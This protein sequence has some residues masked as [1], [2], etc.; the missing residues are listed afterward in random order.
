MGRR[1]SQST[2]SPSRGKTS[3]ATARRGLPPSPQGRDRARLPR[4]YLRRGGAGARLTRYPRRSAGES[5][6][7]SCVSSIKMSSPRRGSAL[8][9]CSSSSPQR[10]GNGFAAR[11]A[12]WHEKARRPDSVIEFEWVAVTPEQIEQ[13]GLPTQPRS[14]R[15]RAGAKTCT[16][17]TCSVQTTMLPK[18]EMRHR[19]LTRREFFYEKL[20]GGEGRAKKLSRFES[21]M[22]Q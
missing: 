17:E 5:R 16:R 9:E 2:A 21:D 3:N 15:R 10:S 1:T 18:Q 14:A 20:G 6:R 22:V 4:V 11:R 7:L 12:I 19:R 8:N 13:Y